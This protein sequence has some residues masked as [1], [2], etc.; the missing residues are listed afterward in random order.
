MIQIIKSNH[1]PHPEHGI[2]QGAGCEE[3]D[4]TG[5][6]FEDWGAVGDL[7]AWAKECLQ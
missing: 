3:C 2:P 6:V 1:P 5:V 4:D 7:E